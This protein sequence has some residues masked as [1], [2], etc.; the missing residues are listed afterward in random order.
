MFG[1]L[2]ARLVNPVRTRGTRSPLTI[3]MTSGLFALDHSNFRDANRPR[4]PRIFLAPGL[5]RAGVGNT[6]SGPECRVCGNKYLTEELGRDGLALRPTRYTVYLVVE[7]RPHHPLCH[8]DD[9]QL[10]LAISG[11]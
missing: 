5:R 4:V 8:H 3:F 6:R 11:F 1:F 10:R 2:P 9:P 7:T